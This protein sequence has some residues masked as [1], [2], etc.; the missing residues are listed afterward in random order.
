M[1]NKSQTADMCDTPARGLC[2]GLAEK[3]QHVTK[4]YKG[5]QIWTDYLQHGHEMG[6]LEC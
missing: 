3:K 6:N 5:P 1:Q 2:G 4:C